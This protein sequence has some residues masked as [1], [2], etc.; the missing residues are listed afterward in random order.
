ME[1]E[2]ELT[3]AQRQ[4]FVSESASQPAFALI[5]EVSKMLTALRKKVLTTGRR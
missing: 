5:T 4:M 3:V 2:T 1:L